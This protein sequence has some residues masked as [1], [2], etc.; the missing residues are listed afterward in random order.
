MNE[1]FVN[2]YENGN[3]ASTN[4]QAFIGLLGITCN[5]LSILVFE[6][7]PLKK[8][9]YSIYWKSIAVFDSLLL[10]HT[11]RH[12]SRR[13]LNADI[14]L[15][16]P[17]FC[18]FNEYQP[19]VAGGVSLWLESVITFDRYLTIVYPNRFTLIK[20]SRFQITVISITV[21]YCLI[22]FIGLPLSYRLDRIDGALIC[23]MPL[24]VFRITAVILVVNVTI[25]N[26]LINP[27]L[28]FKIVSHLFSIRC[29]VGS[30]RFTASDR[31]FAISVVGLN[32]SSIVLKLAFLLGCLLT[33]FMHLNRE[34]TDRVISF[35][36]ILT[37][38]EKADVFVI[39]MAV[40]SVF[41][42]EF[43]SMMG[44]RKE[45]KLSDGLYT[46]LNNLNAVN[47]NVSSRQNS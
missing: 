35:C 41:R 13:V 29:N 20:Q 32:V 36:L 16:S 3:L 39:N 28:D 45:C 12:W 34:E 10:L 7:K 18:R 25:S 15:I 33:S 8:H 9:S 38:V 5:I 6:R 22:V 42:Q 37:L 30:N 31:Q 47:N 19:Y 26:F 43:L 24:N 21:A 40:N 27:F 44:I 46:S 11:F 17:L 1:S 4:I 2:Y 14:D 23:H